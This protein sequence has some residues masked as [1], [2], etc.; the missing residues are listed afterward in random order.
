M[1]Q[2][3]NVLCCYS[4]KMYQVHI[5]KKAPKWHCKVCNAKQSIQ[6][7][8]FQGS[9][10]DCRLH[11]QQLNAK[12]ANDTFFMSS[13]QDDINDACDTFASIPQESDSDNAPENKWTKYLESSEM[14]NL[15]GV[16]NVI[17]DKEANEIIPDDSCFNGTRTFVNI[18]VLLIL[19]LGNSTSIPHLVSSFLFRRE[20]DYARLAMAHATPITTNQF[21]KLSL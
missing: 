21:F 17:F 7:I 12:K 2:E 19:F 9:G 8:Y 5:V 18:L 6:Q 20:N 15:E 4:C 1:P 13:E 16:E 11:V 14:E 3:M 10:R